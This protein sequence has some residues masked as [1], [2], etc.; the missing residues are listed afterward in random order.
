MKTVP[1]TQSA[2]FVAVVQTLQNG[3]AIVGPLISTWLAE[4]IGLGE[5]LVLGA[6]FRFAGFGL[7]LFDRGR[8]ERS[9][10][11]RRHAGAG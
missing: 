5:A 3:Q 4:Y 9:T 11:L 7:F 2:L 8:G 1:E 10:G 6:C